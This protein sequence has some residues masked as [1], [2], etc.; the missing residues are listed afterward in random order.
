MSRLLPSL[1]LPPLSRDKSDMLLLMA[2]CT[3]V[4]LPHMLH[5]SGTIASGVVLLLGWRGWIVF[6][7]HRLP[8][9][10]LLLPVA[11]AAMAAIWLT[12]HTFFGRDAG[13][14]MLTFLLTL[15]LLE[16]HARR[17]MFVVLY[18]S[19]FLLLTS[20]FYSQTIGTALLM[21]VA[22]VALLTAHIAFQ[23][24][25]TV[26]SLLKRVRLP[27]TIVGLAIPLMLVLFFLFPRIQGPLW[28]LPGDANS[29]RSGLSEMMSPGTISDLALSDDIAFRAKFIDPLPAQTQLY[30]R[31][32]VL[33]HYDGR[34]WTQFGARV[35]PVNTIQ[36][37]PGSAP[38]RYEVT[39]E[40]TG[41]RWLYALDV[42]IDMPSVAG[43]RVTRSTTF[44]LL[45]ALPV[46]ERL[47]YAAASWTTARLQAT[48]AA[49]DIDEALQRPVGFNPAT[50]EFAHQL[51]QQSSDSNTLIG[52]VLQYFRREPFRYTLEPPLLGRDSV[53]EFLFT[54]RAG[55]CEHYAGAFVFLMRELGIPA[56]VVTGYQGGAINTVDGYL[57]VRQ[58]DAHAW[59]EVWLEQ[60]GWVR[61]DPTAAV[62]P[63][64]IERK[65]GL[66]APRG[67]LGGLIGFTSGNATW[68]P[69]LRG[70]LDAL[71][72]SWNQWV[73]GYSPTRQQSLIGSLGLGNVDWVMLTLLMFGGGTAVMALTMIPLL[74]RR[75][76][77]APIDR[78]YLRFCRRLARHGV[79]RALNEGPRS[80]R[81]R[82]ARDSTLA[83]AKKLAAGRFLA[84]YEALQYGTVS[85]SAGN[86]ALTQLKALL[87][88]LR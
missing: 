51:L 11:G 71:A 12:Y 17:D 69:L 79:V 60:R 87:A 4:L 82:I 42:P 80:L 61:V 73:L 68:L 1:S 66:R 43:Q 35:L 27:L 38:T 37:L 18:L 76:P 10:W 59:A 22:L 28:G 14:A 77:M 13:V 56:R 58:S 3:L 46:T 70:N 67:M 84:Q 54:T 6:S 47:R 65:V 8:P 63:E 20:F 30:W 9:R 62:A 24:T 31:A 74:G 2:A 83:P 48:A 44:E 29:G 39:M 78:L 36:T 88:A 15:K 53:D 45:T 19:F 33:G 16:M 25:A 81:E 57:E 7:G 64:R 32:A 49:D 55:F 72:N 52:L 86:I 75:A 23:Y 41:R 34:N 26:P 21:T 50:T 40:P 85:P 5:V